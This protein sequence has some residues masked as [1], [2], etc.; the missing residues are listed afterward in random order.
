[1]KITEEIKR[2][3]VNEDDL[4]IPNPIEK[5]DFTILKTQKS[6]LLTAM[7][8]I[9]NDKE[10]DDLNG[11]VHLIDAIQD[12]AVDVMGLNKNDVFDLDIEEDELL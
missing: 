4:T 8:K 11:I 7:R 10:S 3:L 9:C 12:Y 1:M 2:K 6:A 5:I